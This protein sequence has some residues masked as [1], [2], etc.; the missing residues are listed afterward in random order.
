MPSNWSPG[1]PQQTSGEDYS[2]FLLVSTGPRNPGQ[3]GDNFETIGSGKGISEIPFIRRGDSAYVIVSGPTWEEAEANAVKLGGHLV[4]INDAA[5]NEWIKSNFSSYKSVSSGSAD[6]WIGL[7]D[8]TTEGQY[9]WVDGTP[10]AYSGFYNGGVGDNG[11]QNG[12]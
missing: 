4:T 7:T 3:W 1:E 10:F 2:E 5:E 11:S 12:T 6:F 9:E 8:K